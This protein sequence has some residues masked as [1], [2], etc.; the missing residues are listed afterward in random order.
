MTDD[1]NSGWNAFKAVFGYSNHLLCKWHI[2]RSWKRKIAKIVSD[3]YRTKIYQSLMVIL[4]ENNPS[5]FEKMLEGFMCRCKELSNSFLSISEGTI[6]IEYSNGLWY[7]VT[8][9]MV[10]LTQTCT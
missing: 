5:V 2:V 10:T 9:P 8:S 3:K 1:D 7:I 6:F 4:N